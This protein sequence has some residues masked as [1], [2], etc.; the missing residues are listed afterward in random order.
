MFSWF[1]TFLSPCLASVIV[2]FVNFSFLDPSLYSECGSRPE[3]MMLQYCKDKLIL[4][5][6]K[7]ALCMQITWKSQYLAT[8]KNCLKQRLPGPKPVLKRITCTI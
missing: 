3:A 7:K 1:L 2:M 8:K 6:E 4:I 5:Q